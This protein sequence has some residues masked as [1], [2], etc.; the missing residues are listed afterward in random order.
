MKAAKDVSRRK[1]GEN[2]KCFALILIIT[3]NTATTTFHS[4]K[5]TPLE[6]HSSQ[7]KGEKKKTE[8]VNLDT[9]KV[10][11]KK[12]NNKC[13]TSQG[14]ITT[15]R[16]LPL[17]PPAVDAKLTLFVSSFYKQQRNLLFLLE[18]ANWQKKNFAR[19]SWDLST[20]T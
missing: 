6:P 7:E 2:A 14:F 4:G 20:C 12:R 13:S 16:K 3:E 10:S 5:I 8:P 1:R 15:L 18:I 9:L 11:E 17:K 19:V